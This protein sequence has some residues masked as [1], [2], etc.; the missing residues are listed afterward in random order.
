MLSIKPKIALTSFLNGDLPPTVINRHF[1]R[2]T[3]T[4]ISE[5]SAAL[6]KTRIVSMTRMTRFQTLSFYFPMN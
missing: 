5:S 1:D 3:K 4:I 6:Y 2:Y